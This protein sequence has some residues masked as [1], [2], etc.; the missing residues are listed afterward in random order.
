MQTKL[1]PCCIIVLLGTLTI[2]LG[3]SFNLV[4]LLNSIAAHKTP[5]MRISHK[6]NQTK[7]YQTNQTKA[8]PKIEKNNKKKE[9]VFSTC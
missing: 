1:S 3:N 2:G 8:C 9:P 7:A 5:I 4:L 6:P